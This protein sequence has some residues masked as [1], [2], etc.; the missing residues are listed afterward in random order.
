MKVPALHLTVVSGNI[1]LCGES[2][3]STSLPEYSRNDSC[4][5]ARTGLLSQRV[6]LINLTGEA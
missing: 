4:A 6:L 5:F 1:Q 2:R 3:K